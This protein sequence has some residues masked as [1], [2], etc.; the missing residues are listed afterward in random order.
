M[1]CWMVVSL[2]MLLAISASTAVLEAAELAP[3]LAKLRAVG[4]K[5]EGNQAASEAWPTVA[6]APVAELTSVLAAMDG[7][8]PLAENWLRSAAETIAQKHRAALP[9]ADLE[10]FLAD[11][12]HSPRARR[13][14]YELI[15]VV[16]AGAEARLIPGLIDDPSLELRRDAVALAMD[17]AAQTLQSGDKATAAKQYLAAFAASRDLDQVK[18]ITEK[19]K[20]LEVAVDLPTHFGFLMKWQLIGPFDNK[21]GKGYAVA[22]PPE[23]TPFAA[24]A[25]YEGVTGDVKWGGH[26][27]TD[28]YGVVDLNEALGKHKGAIAY[29]YATFDST[30]DCEANFR[31]GSICANKLWVNGKP[32]LANEVYHAGMEVDQYVSRAPLKKGTNTI[33]VM[34]AQNEQTEA[35]AQDWKFQLR[36]C[37][38]IGTPILS[39]DRTPANTTAAK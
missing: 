20:S 28:P 14:A 18:A 22:Y 32:V 3:A 11:T 25:A 2:G 38:D 4:P 6:A 1:R 34:I 17:K 33:L 21:D 8:N 29:A 12:K 7:V 27:T 9:V 37:D 16:D 13:L 36:V 39:A 26:I 30:E 5:G 15:A 23:T 10:K 35:W 19:L 31:L 24:N